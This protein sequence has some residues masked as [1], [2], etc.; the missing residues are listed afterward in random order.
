MKSSVSLDVLGYEC[1]ITV[2]GQN[3]QR[4]IAMKDILEGTEW[5]FS[6]IDGDPVLGPGVK[7]YATAHYDAEKVDKWTCIRQMELMAYALERVG[8]KV[9]RQKVEAIICDFVVKEKAPSVTTQG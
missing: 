3:N 8:Y 4:M 5:S 6:R 7:S 1:H 9:V 2:E